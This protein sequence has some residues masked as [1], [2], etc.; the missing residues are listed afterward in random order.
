MYDTL[1]PEAEGWSTSTDGRTP[2]STPAAPSL[3]ACS[4]FVGLVV[5]GGKPTNNHHYWMNMCYH[6]NHL[7]MYLHYILTD[8]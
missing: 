2:A 4:F 3:P 1:W 8:G 6:P 5:V 7:L